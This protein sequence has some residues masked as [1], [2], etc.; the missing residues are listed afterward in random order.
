MQ[1]EP[2]TLH[3]IKK[4]KKHSA[5]QCKERA[6]QKPQYQAST[7]I[8][9]STVQIVR[10]KYIILTTMNKTLLTS[11]IGLLVAIFAVLFTSCE[12]NIIFDGEGDCSVHYKIKFAYD[13]NMKYADAFAKE[14]SS[15][16]LYIF[17]TN[18]VL[19]YQ[20]NETGSTLADENY[21]MPIELNPGKYN[22]LA[23][24][25]VGNGEY[26]TL[27]QAEIGVT[28]IDELK[29]KLNRNNGISDKE[30]APLFHGQQE[31]TIGE[32]PGIH[33]ETISLTKNTNTVRV[34]LQQL[35]GDDVD[36]SLFSFEIQ[37]YNGYMAHDN[38]LLED[39]LITYKPWSLSTGTADVNAELHSRAASTVG[40]AVAELTT[41]RLVEGENPLLVVKNMAEDKVVLSIPLIDYALLVKGNYNRNM[42]A[43]EYLDRQDEYN[44]TF[45]LD[46]SGEWISSSII[47]NSWRVVL[48][49][50]VIQ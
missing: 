35:S 12:N 9:N 42:S 19:V 43:Q 29:C 40:V 28:S 34:V 30:L 49:N 33:Y 7:K 14:V 37:D 11:K 8:D 15:V 41:A 3:R 10:T 47:I 22:M 38:T 20:G 39:E 46:E 4:T 21:S 1:C 23:W 25:G 36:P 32:E 5:Y 17:D 27:P 45:F 16:S 31:I 26:F 48:K 13:K 50:Q 18:G 2:F 44:L 24:C 6:Q